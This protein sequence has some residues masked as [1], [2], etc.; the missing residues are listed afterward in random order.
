MKQTKGLYFSAGRWYYDVRDDE[1]R[2]K[3][4]TSTKLGKEGQNEV[5][6]KANA[7]LTDHSPSQG[8]VETLYPRF[9][10]GTET[11][12]TMTSSSALWN[13]SEGY[14]SFLR[15]GSSVSL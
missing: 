11:I 12:R 7:W 8:T 1:G 13:V 3:R 4:F 2:L 9:S 6:K 15:S 10:S 5:K 14:T